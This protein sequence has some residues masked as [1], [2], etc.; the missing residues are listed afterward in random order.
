MLIII[1]IIKYHSFFFHP[2]IKRYIYNGIVDVDN[3]DS[4]EIIKLLEVCD[5]LNFNDLVDHLQK[6]LIK[7]KKE[8][9]QHNLSHVY[10]ISTKYQSFNLLQDYFAENPELFLK[11]YDFKL[12]EKSML[13][14]ILE[15]EYLLLDEIDVWDYVV[16]W[17]LEQ[18]VKLGKD[19]SK[20]NKNNF[21]SL[22]RILN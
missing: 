13:M 8:W 20:W 6:F 7:E 21:K 14:S 10:E 15:N 11:T 22:R 4:N 17:G 9:I 3:L 1:L 18:N 12:I 16:Q 5:E 2:F 19:I